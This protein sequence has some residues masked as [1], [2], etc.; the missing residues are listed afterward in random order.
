MVRKMYILLVFI[1]DYFHSALEEVQNI[2]TILEENET[3]QVADNILDDAE[4][5]EV[6]FNAKI[7]LLMLDLWQCYCKIDLDIMNAENMHRIA[8]IL[9]C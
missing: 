8:M 2:L 7:V 6:G 4:N 3:I 1:W 9:V 5:V